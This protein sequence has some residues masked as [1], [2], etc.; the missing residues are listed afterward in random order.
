M[1]GFDW[2]LIHS[3]FFWGVD[4]SVFLRNEWLPG[5][6]FVVLVTDAFLPPVFQPKTRWIFQVA[7]I[8]VK[9][10]WMRRQISPNLQ[11]GN[12]RLSC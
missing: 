5:V 7:Q 9:D 3:G 2:L 1:V 8:V 12:G 4:D 11:G 10:L 6:F